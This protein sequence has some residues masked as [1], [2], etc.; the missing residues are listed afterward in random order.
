MDKLIKKY[1]FGKIIFLLM[2]F[3]FGS[4]LICVL[5]LP[6]AA[7][8]EKLILGF[9]LGLT[10]GTAEWGAQEQSMTKLIDEEIQEAGG[11][12]VKG[13]KVE[14]VF[15]YYD[16]ESTAEVSSIATQRAISDG[17]HILLAPP[18][19]ATTFTASERSERARVPMI[20][21]FCT[22]TRLTER[23]FKYYFRINALLVVAGEKDG[24]KNEKRCHFHSGQCYRNR[25]RKCLCEMDP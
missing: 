9:V 25:Q 4:S 23:G 18:Q 15:K 7:Q 11:I 13:K 22:T 8:A 20:D 2:A 21:P 12:T 17:A 10:G 1:R 24:C 5:G 6:S 3:I 19:S 16:T 14:V